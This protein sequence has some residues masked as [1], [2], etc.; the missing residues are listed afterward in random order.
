MKVLYIT[1]AG[2]ADYQCDVLFHGLRSL[3]G[4]DCV[5][6]QKIWFMYDTSPSYMFHSLYKLLPDIEVDRDDIADKIRAHY[7]DAV[8][9]GSVHRC[10]D[11][12]DL[13]RALYPREKIAYIDGED[14]HLVT[15]QVGHGW[16]FKRELQ[17]DNPGLLPIQFGI[18]EE[19]IRPIDLSR[20]T[21]LMAH[22]D[23]RDRSTYIYYDSEKRYYDQYSDAYFGYT[24]KKGGWD[25]MRH[26]EI[27]AAGTV[28]YFSGIENCPTR[29]LFKFS[30]PALQYAI[31]HHDSWPKDEDAYEPLLEDLRS[32]LMTTKDVAKYVLEHLR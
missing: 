13:V 28:P 4:P 8:I 11:H 24:M 15:P 1:A 31:N 29:T 2:G 22:C 5:D 14:H 26:H 17:D 20:K 21:H 10:L 23:P 27:L 12:F 3:L 16:Y 25:C 7:F 9:F 30:R 32:G 18:P 19:N 6:V